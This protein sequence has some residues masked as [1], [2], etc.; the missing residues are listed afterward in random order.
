MHPMDMPFECRN[1][2]YRGFNKRN[3]LLVT[4][5]GENEFKLNE[6]ARVYNFNQLLKLP[7]VDMRLLK[8]NY[9]GSNCFPVTSS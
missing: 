8:K 2:G 4:I 3:R 9:T 7:G 5:I 1:P 6:I